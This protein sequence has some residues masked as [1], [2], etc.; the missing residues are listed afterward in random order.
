MRI[1][2]PKAA[3]HD[4]PFGRNR[5]LQSLRKSGLQWCCSCMTNEALGHKLRRLSINRAW[6]WSPAHHQ[7]RLMLSV[8]HT[9]KGVIAGKA[10]IVDGIPPDPLRGVTLVGAVSGVFV[11]AIGRT[12]VPNE[13]MSWPAG[14][15]FI[16][17]RYYRYHR[18]L[19][20]ITRLAGVRQIRISWHPIS[21]A[22]AS[23]SPPK[24]AVKEPM[25]PVWNCPHQTYQSLLPHYHRGWARQPY[26]LL[27]Q[28]YAG[29]RGSKGTLLPV[30]IQP[31][32]FHCKGISGFRS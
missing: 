4:Q 26:R 11:S 8:V 24:H 14:S 19:M 23:W 9:C 18:H 20:S 13:H 32:A 15:I 2:Q 31:K 28:L 6:L 12:V 22:K 16:H 21:A 10:S 1:S 29:T 3:C 27:A 7:P 25:Q 30:K 17:L 5:H